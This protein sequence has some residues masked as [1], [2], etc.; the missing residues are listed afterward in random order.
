MP[1]QPPPPVHHLPSPA[2][3]SR[4]RPLRTT[5]WAP[6]PSTGTLRGTP[7]QAAR[8]P[9][10]TRSSGA[11][12]LH[13]FCHWPNELGLGC[14]RDWDDYE[15]RL[16]LRA[17]S[18]W[19]PAVGRASPAAAGRAASG[20]PAAREV[21]SPCLATTP[22]PTGASTAASP[23]TPPT[24]C[25]FR[26]AA[27]RLPLALAAGLR[28]G[29]GAALACGMWNVRVPR[30]ISSRW[31]APGSCCGVVLLPPLHL[32]SCPPSFHAEQRGV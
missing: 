19:A 26:R 18:A 23:S 29:V 11:R 20:H 9:P 27:A 16:R 2:P 17:S 13:S 30:C 3:P 4:P 28:L 10:T 12:P 32:P 8:W 14:K 24:T 15:R 1:A 22:L 31:H 21:H 25:C 5:C 7:R 6:T